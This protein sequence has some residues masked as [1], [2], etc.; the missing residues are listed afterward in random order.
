MS[1]TVRA[2]LPSICPRL[3]VRPPITGAGDAAS[4]S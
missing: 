1:A 2:I 4:V 3:P